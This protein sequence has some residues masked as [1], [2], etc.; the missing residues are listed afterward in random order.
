MKLYNQI[1]SIRSKLDKERQPVFTDELQAATKGIK[2]L[3]MGNPYLLGRGIENRILKDPVF[4]SGTKGIEVEPNGIDYIYRLTAVNSVVNDPRIQWRNRLQKNK[5]DDKIWESLNLEQKRQQ[6][7]LALTLFAKGSLG[8]FR[9]FTWWT[10]HVIDEI[11]V[12]ESAHRMG[13]PNDYIAK[14]ALILRCNVSSYTSA[15]SICSPTTLDGFFSLI[16]LAEYEDECHSGGTTIALSD[17]SEFDDGVTEYV[18]P[19]IPARCVDFIPVEID[20]FIRAKSPVNLSHEFLNRLLRFYVRK[21][22]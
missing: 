22:K 5:S 21:S 13:I 3:D 10:N 20:S 18:L 8:G 1:H 19:P 4:S 11:E 12:V 16:F 14:H 17:S 2:H 7:W 6:D 9:N 15:L